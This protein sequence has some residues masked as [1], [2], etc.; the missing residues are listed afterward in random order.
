VPRQPDSRRALPLARLPFF[1]GWVVVAIAFVTMGIA[2]NSRTA[3]SLLF[4]PILDEFGWPR[5]VTAGAF[6]TGFVASIFYAPLVGLLMDRWGPRHVIALGAVVVSIGL[7][8]ATLVSEPWHFHLT[9]G[10]LVVG[11]SVSMSYIG[12]GAFLPNWFTR[13]RGLAVGIAFSGVGVGSIL[14]LP[15]L[16]GL[17]DAAG[18]RHACLVMAALVLAI[19][20]LNL[21]LQRRRPED[22]GLSP[23]G[24]STADPAAPPDPATARLDPGRTA[25]EWTLRQAVRTARFWWLGAGFFCSLFA[26]YAVQVHQTRYLIDIGF[27]RGQAAYALGLVALFGIGG[28]IAVGYLSDRIG[29]AWAWTV[30]GSGFV[31]CFL[32]LLQLPQHPNVALLYLMVATQGLLGYGLAPVFSAM[33]ADLFPGRSYGTIFGTLSLASSLGA[34]AGPWVTGVLYDQTGSYVAAF[35]LCVALSLAS[36][37]CIWQAAPRKE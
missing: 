20:P 30:G 28:Q 26:W 17:I 25:I 16:Q 24:A 23:D 8:S 22:L 7:A 35:W 15:W 2:V 31:L 32:L 12:H 21:L 14:M 37:A 11:G 33:P 5:G 9:L 10:I 6:S 13:R 19:V 34:A 18:W 3:F 29:R 1:Y 4:P 27:G 36:I